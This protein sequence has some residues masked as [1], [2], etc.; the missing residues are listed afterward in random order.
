M[1]PMTGP[2]WVA[3]LACAIAATGLASGLLAGI[4]ELWGVD[5]AKSIPPLL[6]KRCFS[7]FLGLTVL[8]MVWS[9]AT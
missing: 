2:L 5:L 1:D 8:R 3:G 6:L 9:L 4:G 7:V